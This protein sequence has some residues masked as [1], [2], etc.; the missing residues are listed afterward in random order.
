MKS[1]ETTAPS[2]DR[3]RAHLVI[4]LLSVGAVAAVALTDWPL[5]TLSGIWSDHAMLTNLVS[6]AMFA[7]FTITV[8]ERWLRRQEERQDGSQ[9][10]A[11]QQRLTV[12]SCR[13]E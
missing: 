7:G 11:E 9:R 12:V 1:A 3:R 5:T 2:A 10:R 8:I 4:A 13:D 6:S